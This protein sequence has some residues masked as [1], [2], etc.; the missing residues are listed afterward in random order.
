MSGDDGVK[1]FLMRLD[2]EERSEV[3]KILKKIEEDP[4]LCYHEFSKI[5]PGFRW[6]KPYGR[7]TRPS[8]LKKMEGK[9]ISL[10]K[11]DPKLMDMPLARALEE[12]KSIRDFSKKGL[13]IDVLSTFLYY[14]VGVKGD[15]HGYPLRMFP[16]AGALQPIETYVVVDRVDGLE[17][18]IYHYDAGEHKLVLLK[19]GEF[20]RELYD[21]CLEQEH[22]RDAPVNIVITMVYNRTA[23]K[24][25][26][27]SYRYA[28]L[29]I[30][31]VGMNMY[32]VAT[33]M[34]L[35]TCAIGAFEDD[36]LNKLLELD[37]E[38]EFVIL[39][40]PIGYKKKGLGLL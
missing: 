29:D 12:R 35:G 14:T 19:E 10:P 20:N 33:A 28:L 38:T 39:I 1:D 34:G 3:L 13:T 7:R 27:R 16:S 4:G 2:E 23:S 26:F 17:K 37:T 11:P 21:Y 36:P 18:G 22:V 31:H 30:G 32:L 25:G 6:P 24:Y 40:Y 5:Y 15:K 9:E 8:L